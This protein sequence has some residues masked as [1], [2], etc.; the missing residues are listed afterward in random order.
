MKPE[1]QL[2][3]EPGG[4]VGIVLFLIALM[5]FLNS[6]FFMGHVESIPYSE[7][8]GQ[9]EK[10]QVSNVVLSETFITGELKPEQKGKPKRFTTNAVKDD[11]LVPKLVAKGVTFSSEVTS[12]LWSFF[13]SWI[14]PGIFFYLIWSFL[15]GRLGRGPAGILS[16]TR[17]RAKIYAEKDVKTTFADVAGVDEARGELSEV[18]N[19][20]QDPKRYSRLGG[21]A[22][23]GVL[24]VGPPGTGKTL[25]AR[26]VA[27]E[28]KVPFFSINGS[29]FVELYVGLGAARV[30]DLFEQARRQAPCILFIEEIDA[31]GK[32]RVLGLSGSNDEKEQTLNQ[33]LAEMDGFDPSE[34][35]IMLAAT[36]RPEILDPALLRAGRFDRQI[37]LNNPDQSG[38]QQILRVHVK[39]IRL[40]P[41][42]D[43]KK[44]AALTSGFSGADLA[45]LVNEAAL[46]ATRRGGEAVAESDFSQAIERIVAGLE[47]KGKIMNPREKERV[48]YHELGHATVS[49]YLNVMDRIHKVSI[50]PRGMGALG[51][52]LQR[53]TEDRYVL[54]EDEL[55]NKIAVLLG[56][57]AAEKLFLGKISTGAADDLAKA[58][59]LARAMVSQF[60]MSDK[61][62]M[63]S[64]EGKRAAFLQSPFEVPPKTLSD[65]TA[66]ELDSEVKALLDRAYQ[67]AFAGLRKNQVFVTEAQR[68]L[69]QT[70][71]LTEE[72][73][74]SL[75][76]QFGKPQDNFDV[77]TAKNLAGLPAAEV[78]ANGARPN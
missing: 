60:G 40:D 36:N 29:E 1:W 22:P 25:L 39:K 73:I 24:I 5:F 48:A 59:D 46:V 70:E 72:E 74:L 33:L 43:L 16:M 75:W 31:L 61:I 71:T 11:T 45:N 42:T 38:R 30:R 44:V 13:F 64:Y 53:P 35:V 10:G 78:S 54:D 3:R 21:R 62:G 26:A 20:L 66:G 19:F 51:Y 50:I 47:Q 28:A 52:T 37:L 14:I 49:I 57:R 68:R 69:L 9:L 7:F 56:G 27:G 34:G 77:L 6:L 23:K 67:A 18:V 8:L 55:L 41:Q 32:S 65:N 63:V 2:Q 17:S 4:K 15:M 12:P 76:K 58:T